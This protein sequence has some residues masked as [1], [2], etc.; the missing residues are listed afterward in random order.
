MVIVLYFFSVALSCINIDKRIKEC[1]C[2]KNAE[3][4]VMMKKIRMIQNAKYDEKRRKKLTMKNEIIITMKM[5]DLKKES[6][7]KMCEKKIVNKK[8]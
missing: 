1:R 8:V 2:E 6:K 7:Q 3:K 4:I 5:I